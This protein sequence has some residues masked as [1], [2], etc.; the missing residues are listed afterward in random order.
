MLGPHHRGVR[1]PRYDR[2]TALFVT[3]AL[4]CG[5]CGLARAQTPPARP[6]VTL[7][8][9]PPPAVA[10]FLVQ[11]GEA[12]SAPSRDQLIQQL[13]QK[14]KY[15]F[16]I[17][18]ENH[19]FDNEFGTFPGANGL[20]SDGTQPRDAAHT[21]GF[22]Q[23]YRNAAG[24]EVKAS[25]FRIGPEENATVV[26]SVDHSHTGLA[27]KLHVQNG[28]PLMDL[29]AE[30]EYLR[31]AA[32]GAAGQA[33]GAQ[34]AQLVMSYIDCDTIPFFWNWAS[35]F[36]LFDNIFATED[37]PSTP[38]AIA[39]IAGQ[40]GESQWV[41]HGAQ[42][43]AASAGNHT[44]TLQ[45]PPFANDPQ[46]FWGSQYDVANGGSRQ[47]PGSKLESYA[48]NNIAVNMTSA[49]LPLTLAGR[50]AAD[51]MAQD[52]APDTDLADIRQ[53]I[54]AVTTRG[55]APV[56]WRWYQQGYDHEPMDGAR[57]ATHD[58]FVS[59]HHAPQYFGYI[60][61]NPAFAGNLRGLG[62]FFAD[63]DGGDLPVG[64]GTFYIRGGF[65]NLSRMAPPIQN[66]RFPAAAAAGLTEA[67]IAAITKAKS[68]DDDHPS[69]TDRQISE[70]MAA[71]VV[72][73]IAARPE[74]WNQSA[75]VITYDES[76]GFY[77][78]VPPRILSYG[79]DGLPQ[80]RGIRIPLIVVSPY[81]RAHAVSHAEGD[82]N[83][84]MQLIEQVFDLPALASLPDEK[85]AL[86]AGEDPKF[87]GPNGFVQ[88]H[89]GPRDLNS[90]E[91]DDLLSAF[92][93][94]RLS[95]EL[96]PLPASYA[97]TPEDVLA[98][99]PHYGGKGC[100]AIGITPEDRRQNI[101][102]RLPERFNT[103]PVTLPA[104]N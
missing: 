70:T 66:P 53:D 93:P 51:R 75:I 80:A 100:Q 41:Q 55:G 1:M 85:A 67:D 38:N 79:P 62:D 12:Q 84:V 71:R 30:Q 102:T 14:V 103:L 81:A 82:H 27:H 91:T 92:E 35:R 97:T 73:A 88:H 39:M 10:P 87:N 7:Q 29:F 56:T 42:G 2:R 23:T 20:F 78:H 13:R 65:S 46:P 83:A 101:Q 25:P 33:A 44:G 21:P 59:H 63:M 99:L 15:V 95:G 74:I 57:D 69:Y 26:D 89:L 54:Q 45:G 4:L 77:D 28:V 60:A 61:N 24:A 86:T 11:P 104:Y 76:D 47:P 52:R 17:F 40:S 3:S 16:V 64:G 72:N 22:V 31:F 68:G 19:S 8:P 34:F 36:T 49:T 58:G 18:N 94:K 90:A 96:P 98:S 5:A 37:T 48:D 32:R 50:T 6:L 9:A 43:A